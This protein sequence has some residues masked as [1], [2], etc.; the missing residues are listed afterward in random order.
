MR[1]TFAIVCA[2]L[3]ASTVLAQTVNPSIAISKTSIMSVL[4]YTSTGSG[5]WSTMAWSPVGTP[6]SSDYVIIADGHSVTIDQAV[7]IGNLTV[8][9][10]TSGI[11]TFDGV[12]ARAAS[13]S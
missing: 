7:S 10:G 1:L 12:A 9:Q 13:V 3:I 8:G 6:G 4:T 2:R 5:N 11:L